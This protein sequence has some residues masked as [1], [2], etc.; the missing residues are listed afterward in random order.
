MKKE[1]DIQ[2][3]ITRDGRYRL[4]DYQN[5][6]E[7][8]RMI[9]EH[10]KEIFGKNTYYFDIKKKITGKSGFGT[11]PDGYVI[12]FD[13]KKIYVLEVELIKHDLRKH[14]IPQIMSFKIASGGLMITMSLS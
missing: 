10:S 12:D 8:E 2:V 7:L 5:E 9:V 11:I 14:I 3:I 13:R 4:Y 1:K 6:I